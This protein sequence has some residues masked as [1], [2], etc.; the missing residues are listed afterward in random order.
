MSPGVP[1][2]G[3]PR[4][5]V[6]PQ[7]WQG[8]FATPT[9]QWFART[10]GVPTLAQELA[11]PELV[12]GESVLLLAPTGSGKTLAAFLVAL[13]QR[14]FGSK[15]PEETP[16]LEGKRRQKRPGVRVLYISPLKALASDVERNLLTPLEQLKQEATELGISAREVGVA[17]RTGD[18]SPRLRRA[19]AR[20]EADILITTPESLF[21]MLTS[22][23]RSALAGV[24]TVIVD[25]IHALIGN[26]R[27]AHL[28][29]SLERL[30]HLV[31]RS[32]QRIGL[33][34]TQ[35]PL[36]EVARFL[37][38]TRPVRVI[39]A[40]VDK[41][42][43]LSVE[44]PLPFAEMRVSLDV[45]A[46]NPNPLDATSVEW[47]A[48]HQRLLELVETHQTTLIFVNARRTA[49]RVA[50]ALNR[51]AARTIAHA[52]HG[53]VSKEQRALIEAELK[54]GNL[55]AVV[56]TN[57]LELGIDVG[58]IDLVIQLEAPHSVA[59]TLQRVGR[60]GH[61][62][63]AV[64]S[65][66]LMPKFRGDLPAVVALA[67]AVGERTVEPVR[68]LK[69][70]LDVLAQQV[71]ACVAMDGWC[72]RDLFALVRRSACFSELSFS[73]FRAVL[74]MLAGASAL[75]ELGEISPR[76]TYDRSSG[77]VIARSG[78]QRLV[79]ANAGTIVDRGLYGVYLV[80][81]APGKGR[82]GELDE[83]MVFES[84][85]G[86][87][88]VLGATTWRIQQITADRV[89]V[90]PAPGETGKMPFWRGESAM[91]SLDFGRRIG[92]LLADVQAATKESS[93]QRL[94]ESLHLDAAAA[95][96]FVDYVRE[97]NDRSRLPTDRQIVV[98]TSRGDL[99][100]V[101]VA[102]LSPF[103]AR[104]LSPWALLVKERVRLLFDMEADCNWTNDG[105]YLRLPE[106]ADEV[107]DRR[108]DWCVPSADE[109]EA[110][111][112]RLLSGTTL[113]AGRFREAAARALL[114]PKRRPGKRTP[115][116]QTRK[117]S[118]D[119]LRGALRVRDFPVLVEA[120]RKC[121]VD[122][123]D[124]AGLREVLGA[125][126][127][128]EM[129]VERVSVEAPSPFASAVLFGYA[130]QFLYE[131][132]VPVLE[133]RAAAL[134]IDP[135]RLKELIGPA[136]LR[137]LI[138]PE[139]LLEV[140]RALLRGRSGIVDSEVALDGWHD[141]LLRLGDVL[142]EEV[143]ATDVPLV[144]A[145]RQLGRV[146]ELERGRRRWLVPVEY[147]SRYA[148]ALD[149]ALPEG[150]PETDVS[151]TPL[152]DLLVRYA[153]VHGPFAADV[154]EERYGLGTDIIV[155]SLSELVRAGELV[156]GA[157]RPQELGGRELEFV[158]PAVLRALRVRSLQRL[159][160][161]IAPVSPAAFTRFLHEWQGVALPGRGLDRLLDVIEKLAG[162]PVSVSSF[163]SEILSA[164]LRDY[165]PADLDILAAAGEV[166]WRG[167]AANGDRDGT[168]A[169]YLADQVQLLASTP[170]WKLEELDPVGTRIVALLAD[171]GALRF[172]EIQGHLGGFAGELSRAMWALVWRGIISNDGFAPLRALRGLEGGRTLRPRSGGFRS[173]REVPAHSGGR[174]S[175][176]APFGSARD[177][178]KQVEPLTTARALAW[179][180][181][182]LL[183][184]GVVT[185]ETL[186]LEESSFGSVELLS[187]L[188]AL[189]ENGQVRRGHFV[190]SISA[191]QLASP[192]ALALL[193][194]EPAARE[195][196]GLVVLSAADCANPYGTILPWPTERPQ[197]NRVRAEQPRRVVGARVV[198]WEGHLVAWVGRA[199]KSWVLFGNDPGAS[200]RRALA[201]DQLWNGTELGVRMPSRVIER[202]QGCPA[203]EHELAR[204]FEAVGF[205]RAGSSLILRGVQAPNGR[206]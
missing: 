38:G 29:L 196:T 94:R 9:R 150:V 111:L 11:W 125:V 43:E 114:L 19:I 63:G 129:G 52:H 116:W 206:G 192:R 15:D 197:A 34:A 173:R 39:D 128:G 199:G 44:L 80:G 87:N 137:D 155:D 37:G 162:F 66:I 145:L 194:M 8:H 70:P 149:V 133:R 22:R 127:S 53:S 175:L 45:R 81:A 47:A 176:T 108:H 183:R 161:R 14:L 89:F 6:G 157:F 148:A 71:V 91:R 7:K 135:L 2:H 186:A 146:I 36:E 153:R 104:I 126:A 117:R 90:S 190:E 185:K 56:A 141:R 83:E 32:L 143:D 198:T 92:R 134:A 82:V 13:D 17:V 76:L 3:E 31:G 33:S 72:D 163:E 26:E 54:A 5:S 132:D 142:P 1:V 182:A 77:E 181:Q 154:V 55:R 99:G 200:E 177:N 100:E 189:A 203:T 4:D 139:V 144:S 58:S 28:S 131:G 147:G 42:I 21:L 86:E 88:F 78:A 136:A 68:A 123:F 140:E 101:M 95:E 18:T 24:E 113:L 75:E 16:K 115:L 167:H 159:K 41:S 74:N 122:H 180:E 59:S 118:Q 110:E 61:R 79:I 204:D 93:V 40:S 156:A 23:A 158:H 107:L 46:K 97:Q 191:S 48:V 152:R 109:V 124:V 201:L 30:E 85:P 172:S 170:S 27:G 69:N 165:S 120:Y 187:I 164:R 12:R 178:G 171:R 25:E 65:G 184:T 105:F 168:I 50:Q 195:R 166:V 169:L 35:R 202:I 174:W 103:G 112:T 119:L 10:F 62:V 102:V 67:E 151:T 179:A 20:G 49:E 64:S 57:S 193:R 51:I 138:D 98:E 188:R 160:A 84:A 130:T 73:H 60:A 106:G 96:M 205:V 121:L